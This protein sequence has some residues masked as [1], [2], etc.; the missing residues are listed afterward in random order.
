MPELQQPMREMKPGDHLCLLYDGKQEL[1]QAA[2]KLLM[3]GLDQGEACVYIGNGT[4]AGELM[5]IVQSRGPAAG[6]FRVLRPES[7]Y[8]DSGVFDAQGA[9]DHFSVLMEEALAAGFSGLRVAADTSWAL[10][11]PVVLAELARYEVEIAALFD[12]APPISAICAYDRHRTPPALLREIIAAHPAVAVGLEVW[13]N[14]FYEPATVRDG[15]DGAARLNWSLDQLRDILSGLADAR[16]HETAFLSLAEHAADIVARFDVAGRHLYVNRRIEEVTGR[17]RQEFIGRTNGEL[18]MPPVLVNAWDDLREEVLRTRTPATTEFAF[19]G[20]DGPRHFHARVAPELDSRGSVTGIICITR[21]D[22]N[23]SLALSAKQKAEDQYA[24]LFAMMA[25]GVVYQDGAGEIVEANPAALEMLGLTAD[26][27]S[28][29]ASHDPRWKT[30]RED[31]TAFPGEEHPASIALATG[32]EVDGVMMGVYHPGEERYRWILVHAHPEVDEAGGVAGVFTTF[33][34][35]TAQRETELRLRES[36][37]RFRLMVEASEAVFFY[38]HDLTGRFEYVSP[39]VRNVLGFTADE[40]IGQRYAVFVDPAD[41]QEVERITRAALEKGD[42]APPYR[43]RVVCRDGRPATIEL[44]EAP[45]VVN[46]ELVGMQG[47]GRDITQRALGEEALAAKER[48]LR[49][50]VET[51]NE[52]LLILRED[53]TIAFANPAAAQLLTPGKSPLTARGQRSTWTVV[54]EKHRRVRLR[55]TAVGQVLAR[56]ESV[57]DLEHRIERADGSVV[58]VSVNASRLEVAG[59]SPLLLVTM[60]DVTAHR[61][62]QAELEATN[63]QLRAI[64][65]TSPIAIVMVDQHRR[66]RWWN[67][68][69]ENLFGWAADEVLGEPYPVQ[70]PEDEEHQVADVFDRCEGGDTCE[71]VQVRRLTRTGEVRE[72]SFWNAHLRD[73]E[74]LLTGT[75]GFFVDNTERNRLEEEFRQSQRLEAVGR[76]AGGIAHDFNN[77]LTS[78]LGHA[79]LLLEALTGGPLQE[80]V[81]EIRRSADRARGLTRQLLAFSRKQVLSPVVLDLRGVVQDMERMLGR[82]IGED[83]VLETDLAADLWP[84]LAD[85]T[86]IEQVL[87][88]LAVNAR[89]AMPDGG[90][91]EI[92]GRNL[93]SAPHDLATVDGQAVLV[94]VVDTGTGM[95]LKL[96]PRIFEPFFT[97]KPAG[98][99]TGLGL[100]T[101]HGIVAQSGGEIRVRT[102]RGCGTTFQIYLPRCQKPADA[103]PDDLPAGAVAKPARVLIVE[104]EPGVRSLAVKVLEKKGFQVISAASGGEALALPD[105]AVQGVDVLLS[106]LVMPGMTGREC[107]DRLS[108]RHPGMAVVLMSG[109]SE[110]LVG[111]RGGL[112][113][114]EAF[115][116]KP[117]TVASLMAAIAHAQQQAPAP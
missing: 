5:E 47:F 26:Q 62:A 108:A 56:G 23:E 20:P 37:A 99:G 12:G 59:L 83:V 60:R 107:A 39:S 32:T 14:P 92:R 29:R 80:D 85:R 96:V 3:P 19:E 4:S 42:P 110:T 16:T 2:A 24:R 61:A 18:G 10:G 117:F 111:E 31:G 57:Y 55:D 72:L 86:Q 93:A 28:G 49:A 116:E 68:G 69:A 17:P 115:L 82:I 104:D 53:G 54:D 74:G 41:V 50:I 45:V 73:G 8:L 9:R 77:V 78:V 79:E 48:E 35:V 67:Q 101:V 81:E 58:V 52:A 40:M 36:E 43:V 95:D 25:Q 105:E 30:V 51:M 87:V 106:D 63:A 76:L 38:S 21:D 109:Y 33:T 75:I 70:A 66:V 22:T 6:A 100:A 11:S 89:D 84:V 114:H 13:P 65:D 94:E 1:A 102:A 98:Q 90:K 44:T 64:L 88:N 97:T 27:I 103:V 91:L 113:P 46:G 7:V 34:D 15:G 71:G 112:H